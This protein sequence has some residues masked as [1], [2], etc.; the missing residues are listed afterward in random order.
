MTTCN[1][2]QPWMTTCAPRLSSPLSETLA[3]Q[4]NLPSLAEDVPPLAW[5]AKVL[6]AA[7]YP[8]LQALAGP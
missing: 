2:E 5:A 6:A 4:A 1:F 7:R 3:V 8:A